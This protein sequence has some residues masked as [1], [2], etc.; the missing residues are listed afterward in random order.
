[1]TNENHPLD[2]RSTGATGRPI[3]IS[4]S[5]TTEAPAAC[6]SS[7]SSGES[8][9][10]RVI[11]DAM[12]PEFANGD[13]II[14]EPDGHATDGSFVIARVGEEWTFRRLAR[15]DERWFLVPL[16]PAFAAE[17]IAD[18][19]VVRGVVIQKTTPGRRRAAVRYVD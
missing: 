2:K 5:V 7:C 11:G 4:T 10:L 6:G 13:I 16:N 15:K 12:M 1:M 9:A 3:T 8:F 19:S 14:V 18:L 17:A